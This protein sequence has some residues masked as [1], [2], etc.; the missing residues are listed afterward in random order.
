MSPLVRTFSILA[1]LLASVP[2]LG[3]AVAQDT[4]G[5][6]DTPGLKKA[7]QDMGYEVSELT[8]TKFT[9]KIQRGTFNLPLGAEV[10]GSKGYIWFTLLLKSEL[11]Q[12]ALTAAKCSALLK[13][14]AQI[15]PSQFYLTSKNS[16]MIAL[17][18]ENRNMTNAHLR[19][20]FEKLAQDT[21]DQ[22]RVWQE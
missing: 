10:S 15:Q 3:P 2:L 16:L 17:P 12:D 13:A 6:L 9:F 8:P 21:V 18:V 20:A 4:T 22:A 19:K 11:G 14:N 1:V 7:L 5:Q